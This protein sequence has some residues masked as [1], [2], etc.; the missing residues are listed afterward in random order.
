MSLHASEVER[1][2]NK[3][4]MVRKKTDDYHA[5]FYYEGKLILTTKRSFGSGKIEGPLQHL[6][7][8]QLK[9]T[10]SEFN[11]LIDCTIKRPEYV[12]IL[13]KKGWIQKESTS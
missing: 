6:I 9:L 8:Q 7:R 13:K 2:W 12:A 3:L 10:T 4:D 5:Y 11:E 1:A